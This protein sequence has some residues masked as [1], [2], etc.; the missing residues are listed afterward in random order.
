[1]AKKNKWPRKTREIQAAIFDSTRWN[2]FRF[3]DDDIVIDTWGKSGTTWMQQIVAQ[4]VL[5][6]PE[7]NIAAAGLSPWL[8]MRIFPLDE[9]LGGLEAQTH[10]RFVKTHLP[11]EALVFSPQ[12]KYI[13]V[14]RDARDIVWSAYNHQVSFTQGALDAFNNMPGRVGPP[15]THPPGDVRE[16]Y[17]HFLE[18]GDMPGF[19]LPNLWEHVQGWWNVRE[20][21]NV[22]L[23]HFNDLKADMGREIRRVAR[24]LDIEV[25]EAVWP[26]VMKHCS[27]DYM[28]AESEKID[29]LHQ[30]FDGGGA[31]FVH[32]GTNGRWKDVLSEKEIARCDEVAARHLTLECARWLKTG[33]L[34]KISRSAR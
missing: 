14:G 2:G 17:L 15:V 24:F 27:F 3:R 26:R 9:V 34:P 30:F 21:P 1:M 12:A 7:N 5:G 22:L 4:L 23:V 29:E 8:D 32:K 18:H 33:E 10:R 28:R 6:A 11:L 20:L 19:Q 13:Y 16:Y 31:T 25:D